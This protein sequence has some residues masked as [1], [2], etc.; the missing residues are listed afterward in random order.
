MKM[1]KINQSSI[2]TIILLAFMLLSASLTACEYTKRAQSNAAT[3]SEIVK[4][5]DKSSYEIDARI[6]SNQILGNEI[7]MYGYNGQIPGPTLRVKKGSNITINFKN[8]IDMPTTIH[9]HGIRLENRIDG[10]PDVTQK[11]VKPG[12]SFTYQLKFPDGGIYWYHPHVREDIQQELGMYGAIIVE[13]NFTPVDKEEVI[14]L[15]DIMLGRD[16]Q[17][18][19]F[20][21]DEPN[22]VLMGRFGNV[23]LVN[24]K[25]NY[26]LKVKA[27]EK[28]RLYI[29]NSAN[30]RVFNFKIIGVKLKV[31]GGDSGL[32]EKEF[33]AESVIISPSERIMV[34]L[35]FE[36]PGTYEIVNSIPDYDYS[37]GKLVV[38]GESG[39]TLQLYNHTI[40]DDKTR[41]QFNRP[42]D[43][44]W[45]IG[46][47]TSV[48]MMNHMME[49]GHDGIEWEDTMLMMNAMSDGSNTKWFIKD[50]A[51]GNENMDIKYNLKVGDIKKIRITNDPNSAHPMQHPIHIHGQRFLVL[52]VDGKP[53]DNLV[54]KDTVLVPTG[55]TV[56]ILIDFTNPGTW[57]FHC[58]IAEHFQSGMMGS[59]NVAE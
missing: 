42:P 49:T 20:Y 53:N 55:K 7:R 37:L 4:L 31:V 14:F 45:Q 8:S 9:W 33:M 18:I 19:E 2:N 47:K 48:Q 51:S 56:D 26:N 1:K 34:E 21:P 36:K 41:A 11:E 58:H 16:G 46:I 10:V 5:A 28:I 50:V 29:I 57:M 32:Y 27:G 39:F 25:T 59:I 15:D 38:E 22:F 30:T 24:G 3:N 13:S 6:V 23:M 12:Q 40:L 54:W 43:I 52:S 35:Q 17:I 44:T